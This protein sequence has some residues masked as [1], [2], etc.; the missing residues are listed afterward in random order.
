M[1]DPTRGRIMVWGDQEL[2]A[3]QLLPL[4]KGKSKQNAVF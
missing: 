3:I 1:N 4:L 2:L